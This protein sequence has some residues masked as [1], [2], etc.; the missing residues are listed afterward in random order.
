MHP[1]VLADLDTKAHP[2]HFKEQLGAERHWCGI[3]YGC[4]IGVGP[5]LIPALLIKFA[6]AGQKL[7]GHDAFD[8][9]V[10][11]YGCHVI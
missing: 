11:K 4:R 1:Q 10:S 3:N 6:V 7:L 8:S 9:A 5:V 2:G